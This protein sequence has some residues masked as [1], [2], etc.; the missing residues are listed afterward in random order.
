MNDIQDLATRRNHPGAGRRAAPVY[1][2]GRQLEPEA[3]AEVRELLGPRERRRDLLIEFLHLIQDRYRC[4]SARHLQALAEEMGLPMAE[5]YE[6]ASFYAHF[7]IVLEGETPPPPITIRVCDSLTCEMMGAQAMIAALKDKVG[8]E[9]RV[10]R[11]PC[12]G[13]C[14]TAPVA[15]VGH[16]HID[17]ASADNLAAAAK[18]GDTHAVIPDY[19]DYE[20]Y[21]ADGGYGLLKDCQAG[22]HDPAEI[23]KTMQDSGLRGLGGAGFP[24][25]LKWKI[26]REQRKPRLMAV[27]GDEGEPGTF[28]DRYYL[29][30]DPH[31]FLEG[32]LVAAWACECEAIYIYIRDEY[33]AVIEIL[34]RGRPV[35]P[36]HPVPQHRD[37]PLGARHRGEGRRL[38][39]RPRPQRAQGSALLLG[40]GPGQ[41]AGDEAG[42][43]R[44]HGARADRG[45]LRRHGRGP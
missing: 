20:G 3:L 19:T 42:A 26:L 12:M 15:E 7:D 8:A 45:V 2:K 18:A 32:M 22:K 24:A 1:N 33:P 27:N 16:R 28:K 14:D 43:R 30:R 41:G 44:H 25:G 10:V 23:V 31:R 35:R 34:K 39:R 29:E 5:V 9:V 37:S 21:L 40:L 38:V 13:R 11:A 6:V 4:L 17:H 36:A